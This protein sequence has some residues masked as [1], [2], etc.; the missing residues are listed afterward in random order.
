[1][2]LYPV[3]FTQEE[4]DEYCRAI[5]YEVFE[6]LPF[7]LRFTRTYEKMK[8]T[9][10]LFLSTCTYLLNNKELIRYLEKNRFDVVFTDPLITCG[11]IIAE[12]L[13]L[14]CFSRVEFHVV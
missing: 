14:R 3:P 8:K 12:Y 2:K 4:V 11:Q 1:M 5:S 7:L 6:E 13:S 10:S 9:T